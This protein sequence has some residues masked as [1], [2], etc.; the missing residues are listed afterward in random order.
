MFLYL[1]NQAGGLEEEG[2]EKSLLA[3]KLS[4]S[5]SQSKSRMGCVGVPYTAVGV[6]RVGVGVKERKIS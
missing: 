5:E 1:H 6:V 2:G 4:L 3:S